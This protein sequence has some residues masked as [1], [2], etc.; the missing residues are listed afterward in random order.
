VKQHVELQPLMCS[1]LLESLDPVV[2]SL[3][4][5]ILGSVAADS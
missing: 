3:G 2:R 4:I 5:N 1:A